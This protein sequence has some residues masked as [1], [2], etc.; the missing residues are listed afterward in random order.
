MVKS[1][2]SNAG[3]WGS[4]PGQGTKIPHASGQISLCAS[5]TE[6]TLSGTCLL[7]LEKAHSRNEDPA[8]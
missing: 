1:L 3:D 7:K 5:T 6:P 8:R 4:V 2:P